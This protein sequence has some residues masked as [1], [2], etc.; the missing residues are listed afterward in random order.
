MY[1]TLT[2]WVWL[3]DPYDWVNSPTEAPYDDFGFIQFII[4][5][6]FRSLPS[7][8]IAEF[9]LSGLANIL[10]LSRE[11]TE[12]LDIWDV[13]HL[14]FSKQGQTELEIFYLRQD[15]A[16]PQPPPQSPET[17]ISS[18]SMSE[19]RPMTGMTAYPP[20]RT[21]MTG[22][23][24]PSGPPLDP[25]LCILLISLMLTNLPY[26]YPF[27]AP[28]AP[29]IPVGEHYTLAPRAH[30]AFIRVKMLDDEG[31]KV[32]WEYLATALKMLLLWYQDSGKWEG[33]GSLW[34]VE[35]A[36]RA[37]LEVVVG[38][39]VPPPLDGGKEVKLEGVKGMFGEEAAV[40]FEGVEGNF[41]TF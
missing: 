36:G 8:R 15:A 22:A 21:K 5:G 6:V 19:M 3:Q 34:T 20:P 24:T 25:R 30:N 7:P 1:L 31:G 40:D 9:A 29:I 18:N 39:G 13:P 11:K 17:E 27:S 16:Q 23:V 12:D 10:N 14:T 35:G 28:V 33:T 37:F 41:T 26:T 2:D 32:S 4:L 38:R